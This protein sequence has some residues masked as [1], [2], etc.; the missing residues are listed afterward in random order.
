MDVSVVRNKPKG[1][2][3]TG[4]GGELGVVTAQQAESR[5][6]EGNAASKLFSF[7]RQE[8]FVCLM[9]CFSAMCGSLTC[10][11]SS[12]TMDRT[13]ATSVKASNPNH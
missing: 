5:A 12:Q 7:K 10:D 9:V 4:G 2:V 1:E 11:H 8:F 3:Q 6:D 13:R